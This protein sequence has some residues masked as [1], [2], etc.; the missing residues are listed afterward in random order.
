MIYKAE[1]QLVINI[2]PQGNLILIFLVE[3]KGSLY[4]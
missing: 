4:A 2:S 3:V 1:N